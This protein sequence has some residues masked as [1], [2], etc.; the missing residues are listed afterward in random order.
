LGEPL[1]VAKARVLAVDDDPMIRG[2][3]ERVLAEEGFEVDAVADGETAVAM[4][5][6]RTPDV[7]LL[8]IML[9]SV[10]GIDVLT[11]LRR[12]SDVPVIMLTARGN[13]NDRILGL[14]VGADDYLVKPFSSGEL[15]ARIQSLLRRTNAQPKA[16]R[17]LT[18]GGMTI[19]IGTREV[20][21]GEEQIVM[22]AKEFD[23]LAFMATS[24]RQVFSREQLL[25]QVWSSSAQWQ[26]A[27]T[28]TEHVRRV[29][30][31]IETDPDN[32]RWLRTVRGVGYRFEPE[33]SGAEEAKPAD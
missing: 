27:A 26:D 21:L 28:V 17:R 6:D 30:R 32:P 7:V 5:A 23:L 18:F 25:N 8:D 29:R 13:E 33:A 22:T 19:D 14:R 12:T 24:P 31:K 11:K 15:V 2:L 10:D 1:F 3:L 9:G 4:V 16:Q 20:W